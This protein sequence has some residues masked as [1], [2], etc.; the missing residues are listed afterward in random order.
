MGLSQVSFP[1]C[2]HQCHKWL[3][4]P[5]LRQFWFQQRT[6]PNRKRSDTN[7]PNCSANVMQDQRRTCIVGRRLCIGRSKS[8]AKL[9][10]DWHKT[11][12][13]DAKLTQY[14]RNRDT[15]LTQKT[16]KMIL[17][18]LIFYYSSGFA[19]VASTANAFRRIWNIAMRL[20]PLLRPLRRIR[21]LPSIQTWLSLRQ[22]WCSAGAIN[23]KLKTPSVRQILKI[24]IIHLSIQHKPYSDYSYANK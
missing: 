11:D 3:F 2:G 5:V 18:L 13:S 7:S 4:K 6:N 14:H 1:L 19:P 16:R 23:T 10:L 12:S 15:P 22:K 24:V 8:F 21:H 9:S 20:R 17:V